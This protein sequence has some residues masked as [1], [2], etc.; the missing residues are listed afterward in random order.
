MIK[1]TYLL[2]AAVLAMCTLQACSEKTVNAPAAAPVAV[3]APTPT[4]AAAPAPV[5]AAVA[6][7]EEAPPKPVAKSA[8]AVCGDRKIVV[9]A[10]CLDLYGGGMLSCTSQSIKIYED[11]SGKLLG[12]KTYGVVKGEGDEPATVDGKISELTCVTAKSGDKYIVTSMYNGG[13]CEQ[14]EWHELYSWDGADLGS[15]RDR[16]VKNKALRTALDAINEKDVDNTTGSVNMEGFYRD[17]TA[18]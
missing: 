5:K 18:D 2:A 4:P 12:T 10:N 1:Q 13:N 17:D 16:K 9:D 6:E 7:P 8:N 3:P 11:G 14:C 15:D